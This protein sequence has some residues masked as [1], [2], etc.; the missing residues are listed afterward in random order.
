MRLEI[1][2]VRLPGI[3]LESLEHAM[4][5]V[6]FRMPRHRD[7]E[8]AARQPGRELRCAPRREVRREGT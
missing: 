5:K 6:R 2:G 4:D 1:H 3:G 7:R 8:H